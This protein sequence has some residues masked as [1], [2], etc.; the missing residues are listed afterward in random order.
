MASH[1]RPAINEF[2]KSKPFHSGYNR[3]PKVQAITAGRPKPTSSIPSYSSQTKAYF[4][5]SKP[6]L[7][8]KK[9]LPLFQ[10]I[11]ERLKSTFD[12]PSH[13]RQAK[14]DIR[15]SKPFKSGQN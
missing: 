1:S 15:Q 10:A 3:L 2:R 4:L 11:P 13:S 5:L 14:T 9:R 8:C 6:F 12:I 7:S